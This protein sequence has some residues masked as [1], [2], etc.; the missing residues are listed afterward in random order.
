LLASALG[1][2]LPVR[3]GLVLDPG[4]LLRAAAFGLLVAL[5]FAAPPIMRARDFP[6]MA[7]MR[8]RIAP[9]GRATRAAV[10]PV[11]LGLGGIA[12]LAFVGAPQPGLTAT[13]LAGAI[14]L[15]GLLE[16][17]GWAIRKLAALLPRPGN[18]LLR[19]AISNLH[20]PGSSTTALVTALGF[21]LSAFVLLAA[22]QT[23]LDGNIR[24]SVPE[25]APDYFVLDV[26]RE[27]IETFLTVVGRNA[28]G[29]IVR[30][31]PTLRGAVLAYGPKSDMTRVSE[32][33]ELPEGAWALSGER[34]LT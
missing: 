7:L 3:S 21:G 14:V 19:A 29:S 12:A 31:V 2:L 11:G 23:S 17:L 10:L 20:R 18:P 22:V 32:L 26:P 5:V 1:D 24:R 9:L 28:P 25:R 30:T 4:A 16:L 15:L 34:G 33:D 27:G 6:A 8:A 13:F